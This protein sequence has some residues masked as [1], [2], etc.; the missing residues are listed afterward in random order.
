MAA[1][2]HHTVVAVCGHAVCV[3]KQTGKIMN[4]TLMVLVF[5]AH[6]ITRPVAIR[7]FHDAQR[8]IYRET[9]VRYRARFV[10]AGRLGR[11]NGNGILFPL[12]RYAYGFLNAPAKEEE[13]IVILV[14]ARPRRVVFAGQ[15]EI[16]GRR[17]VSAVEKSRKNSRLHLVHELG[18]N[19]G[20]FHKADG[21][22]YRA[23]LFEAW[24]AKKENRRMRFTD[25]NLTEMATCLEKGGQLPWR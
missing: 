25:E 17:V 7:T 1:T 12:M 21:Y 14:P 19:L 10:D 23:P 22:M 16:C 2:G 6:S 5:Y 18:H 3:Y 9:G 24:K 13:R 15:A 20:M 11:L 8:V 4:T